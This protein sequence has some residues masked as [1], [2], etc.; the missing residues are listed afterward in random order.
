M[1]APFRVVDT[2][3]HFM[4]DLEVVG[5]YMP[6]PWKRRLAE[7]GHHAR[8]TFFPGSSG[9]RE[10]W[11]RIRREAT[12]YPDP[13]TVEEIRS[14]MSFI[15]ADASIQLSQLVLAMPQM[16]ANDDRLAAFATGM[17]DYFLA[18]AVDPDDG[19]HV[20]VPIPY[21]DVEASVELIERVADEPGVAAGCM[22]TAGADP[23][24]GDERYNPIYAA[25][26][27]A[28]LPMI[29]HS[30]G[31]GLDN[32]KNRG[33]SKLIETHTLGF[34]EGNMSQLTSLIVQGVPEKFPDMDVIF[35]ESGVFWVPMIMNRLDEEYLKR[36]FE[37]PLLRKRPS[38]YMK[39][40]YYGTQPFECSGDQRH[41]EY[42]IEMLGGADR[43]MYASDYPHWDYDL[44]EVISDRPFL[45][46]EEKA[47]ILGGNA[48]E[49]FD[50]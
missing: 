24:L 5:E 45:S 13:M 17:V 3:V 37:A 11:G 31:A 36:P 30:G 42:T 35:Q 19:I 39:E 44:P 26:E 18:E 50:L 1:A 23:P 16:T 10:A 2:D 8:R 49:V 29:F 28:G 4:E 21:P 46:E 25:A 47:K 7:G 33:Y 12:D 41:L 43:L 32:F 14:G 9:H 38:E 22:I 27:D 40:F 20:G 34:I 15:G 48:V 6:Q